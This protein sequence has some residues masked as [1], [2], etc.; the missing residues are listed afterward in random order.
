MNALNIKFVCTKCGTSLNK[1]YPAD[2]IAMLK[3]TLDRP[4]KC[5]CG[6]TSYDIE[7]FSKSKLELKDENN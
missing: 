2:S 4:D 6:N 1:Y 3:K 5:L 7:N